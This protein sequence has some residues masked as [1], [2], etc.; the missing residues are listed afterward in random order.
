MACRR[1]VI[2]ATCMFLLGT[3]VF[4]NPINSKEALERKIDLLQQKRAAEAA[5]LTAAEWF[6]LGLAYHDLTNQYGGRR[7]EDSVAA[8][9]TS[10]ALRQDPV[11]LAYL[12]SAWTLVGRDAVNPKTK[13]D[14]VMKGIEFLDKAVEMAPQDV[15]VRRIRY[16]N[17]FALPDIFER[18]PV[19]EK[20]VDY[21]IVL[22]AKEPSRFQN[23]YDPAHVF[24]FKARLCMFRNDINGARKYA[25]LAKAIVKD[26]ELQ[27][28]IE[29][30][31]Q[32]GRKK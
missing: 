2:K 11:T 30:F 18:K 14:A 29:N 31:L 19:A 21:L 13:I 12:G 26:K 32:G 28:E 6:E 9:E 27:I 5:T 17:S 24:W 16:E 3:F 7:S 1:I 10:Y 15:I 25:T 23:A 20:D 8:F 22:Y 4:G